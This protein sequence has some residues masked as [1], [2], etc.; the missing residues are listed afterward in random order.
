[1]M[2]ANAE[3]IQTN[4]IGD[5]DLLNEISHAIGGRRKPTC[6]RIRKN[7]RET[8]DTDFH[9]GPLQIRWSMRAAVAELGGWQMSYACRDLVESA[10]CKAGDEAR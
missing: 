1:M 8:V 10:A 7:G 5:F 3:D 6:G 2:L 9:Q 4:P